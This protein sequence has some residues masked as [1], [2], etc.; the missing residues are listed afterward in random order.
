MEMI[1]MMMMMTTKCRCA[2]VFQG[3]KQIGAKAAF[4]FDFKH[5]LTFAH[6]EE[7]ANFCHLL[8]LQNHFAMMNWGVRT[9]PKV[10][11]KLA[12]KAS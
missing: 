12:P 3:G 2:D 8:F 4:S 9:F 5:P 6:C 11:N 7:F 10:G 1:M